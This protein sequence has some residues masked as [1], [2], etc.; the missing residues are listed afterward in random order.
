VSV[1]VLRVTVKCLEREKSSVD[2]TSRVCF[3]TTFNNFTIKCRWRYCN[4]WC[5]EYRNL[6][7]YVSVTLRRHHWLN[8]FKTNSQRSRYSCSG[9]VHYTAIIIR[10]N[11]ACKLFNIRLYATLCLYFRWHRR[12]F[13]N[14]SVFKLLIC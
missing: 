3:H 10:A 8:K 6:F 9:S 7:E 1:K 4:W 13:S 14:C 5:A 11:R 12:M 2:F